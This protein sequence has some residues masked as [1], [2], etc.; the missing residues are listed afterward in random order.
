[1]IASISILKNL[2]KKKSIFLQQTSFFLFLV[3]SG[4]TYFYSILGFIRI[5]ETDFVTGHP[6][7]T[8]FMT[9]LL[10]ANLLILGIPSFIQN[11]IIGNILAKIGDYSYSLYLLHYPI[12]I[13]FLYEPFKGTIT[14]FKSNLEIIIILFL[15]VFFTIIFQKIIFS[16]KVKSFI[17]LEIMFFTILIII[18]SIVGLFLKE[19]LLNSKELKIHKVLTYKSILGVEKF[20]EL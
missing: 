5:N 11:S 6:G 7:I 3:I 20:L 17:I 15:I 13:F 16:E 4:L 9:C 14:T 1:M 10:T 8:A 2:Y 18:F 12:I 19:A